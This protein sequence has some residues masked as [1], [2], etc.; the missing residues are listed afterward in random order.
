[1]VAM[2]VCTPALA[3]FPKDGSSIAFRQ[4]DLP[5][6]GLANPMGH[7][8]RQ[9]YRGRK[10]RHPHMSWG[11]MLLQNGKAPRPVANV[12]DDTI[13]MSAFW[14]ASFQER[15]CLV[16]AT[17]FLRAQRRRKAPSLPQDHWA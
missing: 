6:A 13:L 11:F 7:I 15:R 16:L 10:S 8:E 1:M 2:P 12:R 4:L 5:G 17:S 9:T 3:M 14:K